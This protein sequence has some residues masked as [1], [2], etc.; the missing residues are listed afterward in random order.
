[1]QELKELV[2]HNPQQLLKNI[3]DLQKTINKL[4]EQQPVSIDNPTD[5]EKKYQNLKETLNSLL[6]KEQIET[7]E[8]EILERK[9]KEIS[10]VE[11]SNNIATSDLFKKIKEDKNNLSK[12]KKANQKLE[13]QLTFFE[14]IYQVT[15]SRIK[16][17]EKELEE[18]KNNYLTKVGNYGKEKLQGKFTKLLKFQIDIT[19]SNAPSAIDGKE[20]IIKKLVGKTSITKDELEQICSLQEQV[21]QLKLKTQKEFNK[22][23]QTFQINIEKIDRSIVHFESQFSDSASAGTIEV[24]PK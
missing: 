18:L 14:Q 15:N 16:Q 11:E 5:F 17:K 1:I 24:S 3:Q 13:K 12:L 9:T 22:V 23:D 6:K 19:T 4:K 21:T 7:E 8:I 10:L 20:E 2:K